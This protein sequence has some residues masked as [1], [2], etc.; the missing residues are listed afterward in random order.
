M[1]ERSDQR[2]Q[3][4]PVGVLLVH[5]LN[6]SLRDMDELAAFLSL[7]GLYTRL[8]LLPGHGTHVNDMLAI[9]WGE[10]A[11]AVRDELH[12][13]QEICD[14][15]F[16]IGHSL[17]GALCLHLAAS[18]Q[19]A[20]LITMCAPVHMY[21]GMLTAIR[22]TRRFIPMVPTIREDIRDPEARKRHSRDV[23]RWTPMAPV[24]SMLQY[25]PM[26]RAELPLVTAPIL[27]MT[28]LHDHVVPASDGRAIYRMIGSQD[29]HLVTLDRSYHM[30]VKDHDREEVFSRTLT[31]LLR[32]II[33]LQAN[34]LTDNNSE[35]VK[36]LY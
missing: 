26:L 36:K 33:R 27:I 22:L 12:Q 31:F 6:G 11:Q 5:G 30:I 16:L 13:L 21:P 3:K 34:V 28:A 18:E 24:E 9:G 7:N 19:I 8:V 20:G 35:Q 1:D 2:Q 15:V 23:Y 25:L 4:E 29:K 32:H 10:W 17:G 14:H